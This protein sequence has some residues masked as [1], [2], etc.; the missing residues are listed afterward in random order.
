[1]STWS[2]PPQR[3]NM[4]R[5]RERLR[6][7]SLFVAISPAGC[8]SQTWLELRPPPIFTGANQLVQYLHLCIP[9]SF[10]CS[11][12]LSP[13]PSLAYPIMH[14]HAFKQD[15]CV[16][17][18]LLW[19]PSLVCWWWRWVLRTHVSPTGGERAENF[20][21]S[22]SRSLTCQ[23]PAVSKALSLISSTFADF[24]PHTDFLPS[25]F[26]PSPLLSFMSPSRSPYS[27]LTFFRSAATIHSLRAEC[28]CRLP[29]LLG[30]CFAETEC[31]WMSSSCLCFSS[32]W[33]FKYE[34]RQKL[35]F[36]VRNLKVP[37]FLIS[38]TESKILSLRNAYLKMQVYLDVMSTANN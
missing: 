20:P 10:S 23:Q 6:I 15:V 26:L 35:E 36:L 16:C 2:H 25:P 33:L 3:V 32:S 29:L 19:L 31:F 30:V 4:R 5:G 11:F 28:C 7:L 18:C 27:S 17:V 8:S 13:S 9:Q 21:P 38:D 12:S 1:M 22:F 24:Q 14:I 37:E 34:M